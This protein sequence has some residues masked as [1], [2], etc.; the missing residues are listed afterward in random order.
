MAE[1]KAFDTMNPP[2]SVTN[3]DR[4]KEGLTANAYQEYPRHL[5]RADGSF[6]EVTN[7]IEK[8][9]ALADGW[10]LTPAAAQA[11]VSTPEPEPPADDLVEDRPRRGR[12]PAADAA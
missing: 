12:R 10:H 7:D 6:C 3:P 9:T 1:G 11:A 5:H 4:A 2:V 8:A